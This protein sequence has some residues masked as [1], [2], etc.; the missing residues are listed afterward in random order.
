MVERFTTS[1]TEGHGDD[2]GFKFISLPNGNKLPRTKERSLAGEIDE[3]SGLSIQKVAILVLPLRKNKMST[4]EDLGDGVRRPGRSGRGFTNTRSGNPT[5]VE[6]INN[7][8][9]VKQLTS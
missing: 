5:T 2:E 8:V 6:K 3:K 9:T 1:F 4:D 7:V